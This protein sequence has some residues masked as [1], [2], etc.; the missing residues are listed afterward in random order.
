META[1]DWN[2]LVLGSEF[3]THGPGFAGEAQWT[4]FPDGFFQEY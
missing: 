2:L 4:F 1:A 3:W